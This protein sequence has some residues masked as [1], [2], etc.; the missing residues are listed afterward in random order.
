MDKACINFHWKKYFVLVDKAMQV[1]TRIRSAQASPGYPPQEVQLA[2]S[3]AMAG[4]R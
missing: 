2:S 4:S 3:K 1:S